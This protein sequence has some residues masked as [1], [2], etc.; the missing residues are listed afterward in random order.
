MSN[1]AD[2]ATYD[3][4]YDERRVESSQELDELVRLRAELSYADWKAHPRFKKERVL[5]EAQRK[6][7]VPAVEAL[8]WSG[9][10]PAN[11]VL[12]DAANEASLAG[13]MEFEAFCDARTEAFVAALETMEEPSEG[14]VDD[15]P[16]A[17]RK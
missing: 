12:P 4:T 6:W 2:N 11:D 7:G 8:F 1:I 15:D 14:A 13:D 16:A 17:R 9:L 3:A 5:R 10:L